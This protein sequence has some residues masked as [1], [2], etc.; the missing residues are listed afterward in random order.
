MKTPA[1]VYAQF[2]YNS[3]AAV[4][5]QLINDGHFYALHTRVAEWGNATFQVQMRFFNPN[6]HPTY[7]MV[8]GVAVGVADDVVVLKDNN[9]Q[10]AIEANG[11]MFSGAIGP[12]ET[13]RFL[14]DVQQ[15]GN[16]IRAVISLKDDNA[17]RLELR[18]N[19]PYQGS[20]YIDTNL[21]LGNTAFEGK[22]LGLFGMLP[23]NENIGGLWNQVKAIGDAG[24]LGVPVDRRLIQ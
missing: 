7:T 3:Y 15:S 11:Q 12:L 18:Y 5:G 16:G 9:G 4:N 10:L 21:H 2:N 20:Y 8:N 17:T 13:A 6:N 23:N 19:G 22:N 14:L 1:L 24:F